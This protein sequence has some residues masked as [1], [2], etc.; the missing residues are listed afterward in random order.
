MGCGEKQESK[1]PSAS[2]AADIAEGKSIAQ[3]SCTGCHGM[4]GKGANDNIPNLAAQYAKYLVDSLNAYKEDK[5]IHAALKDMASGMSDAQIQ[6]VANYYASLPPV[7]TES[8]QTEMLSPYEKGKKTAAACAGCHGEDGNST[9]EGVPN[10]A[11]QQ[12]VYFISAVNDYLEGKR[13]IATAEKEVMVNALNRVDIESMAL[14]YASQTPIKRDAP[15]VG[16]PVKGQPLSGNCGGCHGSHGI[17]SDPA[18]P[19][20]AS[21][22]PYYIVKATKEYRDRVRKQEDMHKVMTDIK[23]Q[24]LQHI[25]AY[26]AVQQGK[27]A[28]EDPVS[29][30]ALAEQCDRCHAPAM[31]SSTAVVFPKINGQN[32]AYLIKALREYRDGQRESSTMHKMSLPYSDALIESIADLYSH[33]AA[34]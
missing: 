24:E 32:K 2:T 19:S 21:Q 10:L 13:D 29:V 11:G 15:S 28:Q 26:Y 23:D 18:V 9:K 17:S 31:E 8:I 33:R 25:A 14:Y 22:D 34:N 3:S 20:L 4:D 5:R 7:K 16:D 1:P 30:Q 6:N 12:P 27:P